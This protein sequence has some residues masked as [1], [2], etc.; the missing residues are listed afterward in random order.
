[1]RTASIV[2]AFIAGIAGIAMLGDIAYAAGQAEAA[3]TPPGI[4]WAEVLGIVGGVLGVVS[5]ILHIVAP[6]TKTHL[7]DELVDK[8]DR[9]LEF[10]GAAPKA[11]RDD[12]SAAIRAVKP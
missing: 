4:G 12:V 6:R 5:M 2:F 10:I 9:V 3:G 7:D 11:R 8:I 1:M